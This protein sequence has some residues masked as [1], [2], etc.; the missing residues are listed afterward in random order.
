MYLYLVSAD[1]DDDDGS[2]RDDD[3]LPITTT[4]TAIYTTKVHLAMDENV[5]VSRF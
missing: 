5:Q 2:Q 1:D 3:T 4:A